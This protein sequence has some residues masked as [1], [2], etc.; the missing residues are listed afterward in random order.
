M[1]FVFFVYSRLDAY[2]LNLFL[3]RPACATYRVI[4]NYLGCINVIYF[5]QTASRRLVSTTTCWLTVACLWL[6]FNRAFWGSNGFNLNEKQKIK[7]NVKTCAFDYL[8]KTAYYL[9]RLVDDL[10][11]NVNQIVL[12]S[13]NITFNINF[14]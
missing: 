2:F 5:A 9:T 12:Q 6:S 7:S 11:I 4:I 1:G 13:K 8:H 10:V 3:C 14:R